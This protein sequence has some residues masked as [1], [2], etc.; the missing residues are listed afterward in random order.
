MLRYEAQLCA[1]Y[2]L[3]V[4]IHS[5]S[6]SKKQT[7]KKR[8]YYLILN[9]GPGIAMLLILITQ[10]LIQHRSVGCYQELY[11]LNVCQKTLNQQSTLHKWESSLKG[12]AKRSG[13]CRQCESLAFNWGSHFR[14]I[15]KY[16][17][18]EG[19]VLKLEMCLKDKAV[20]SLTKW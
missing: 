1:S 2:L 20:C 13:Q 10:R 18:K 16:S 11:C 12:V 6:I 4:L 17:H 7:A 5:L 3:T 15:K 8:L 14:K 9:G 19:P